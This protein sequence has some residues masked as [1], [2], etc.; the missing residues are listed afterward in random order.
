MK[1]IHGVV[2]DASA[3]IQNSPW[4][5]YLSQSS[6]D[7]GESVTLRNRPL[8]SAGIPTNVANMGA[9]LPPSMNSS[10]S[11]GS[12]GGTPASGY[13]GPGS[14]LASSSVHSGSGVPG[15]IP[16]TP[17]SAALGPA[18]MA[19]LPNKEAVAGGRSQI[20][21]FER[22]DRLAATMGKRGQQEV[23]YG[24]KQQPGS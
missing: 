15:S 4:G 7:Q 24:K 17:L 19:T 10:Y 22:V 20:N 18:A 21:F 6:D 13:Y 14:G 11:N 5:H 12:I 1:Q 23:L 3:R 16:S 9:M 8:P 2:K